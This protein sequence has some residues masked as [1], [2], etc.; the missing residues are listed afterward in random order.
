MVTANAAVGLWLAGKAPDLISATQL[1][2]E[3]I[4]DGR[5]LSQLKSLVEWTNTHSNLK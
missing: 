1:A 5:A 3:T 4:Q 2:K